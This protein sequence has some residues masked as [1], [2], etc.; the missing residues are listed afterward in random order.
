MIKLFLFLLLIFLPFLS[1]PQTDSTLF[2]NTDVKV[3]L[4]IFNS[5]ELPVTDVAGRLHVVIQEFDVYQTASGQYY[6]IYADSTG[7]H[8]RYLGW[9]TRC[10][11]EGMTVFCNSTKTRHWYLQIN[12]TGLPYRVELPEFLFTE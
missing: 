12:E 11:Y 3:E 6:I 1:F 10:R 9:A 2:L 4:E 5:E 7:E 8:R